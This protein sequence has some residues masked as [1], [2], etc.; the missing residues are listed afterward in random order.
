MR[1]P[2]YYTARVV[3]AVGATLVLLIKFMFTYSDTA[4]K[5]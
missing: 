3:P 4:Y 1:S 2:I 5:P